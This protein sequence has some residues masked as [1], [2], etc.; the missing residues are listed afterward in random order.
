MNTSLRLNRG[1]S[2]MEL[3]IVVGII[4]ILAA[5]AV[6]SYMA[7]SIRTHRAAARACMSEAAQFM[8]RFYTTRQTYEGADALLALGCQSESGLNTHYTITAGAPAGP[9][10]TQRTFTLLATP[11]AA[12]ANSDTLCAVLSLDQLGTRGAT[13]TGGPAACW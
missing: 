8:E 2:L 1:V 9:A 3:M 7:Y 11:I 6:P 5:I 10:P 12:Q 4:G 13:G